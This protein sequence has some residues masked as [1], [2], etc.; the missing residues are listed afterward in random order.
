M[1][2]LLLIVSLIVCF[3]C[4]SRRSVSSLSITIE[5]EENISSTSVYI[6]QVKAVDNDGIQ[7]IKISIPNLSIIETYSL[8]GKRKWEYERE[9]VVDKKRDDS[10]FIIVYLIDTKGEEKIKKINLSIP[11]KITSL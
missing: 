8:K 11:T 7:D 5:E 9:V 3:S 1:K 4:A 10:G 2:N 6:V